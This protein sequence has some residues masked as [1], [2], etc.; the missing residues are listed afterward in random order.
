MEREE[1]AVA[2][3][4]LDERPRVTDTSENEAFDGLRRRVIRRE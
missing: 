1:R 2:M 4:E 3:K